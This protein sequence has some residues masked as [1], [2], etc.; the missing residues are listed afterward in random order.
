[1]GLGGFSAFFADCGLLFFFFFNFQV[2]MLI[3]KLNSS[4]YIQ[5]SEVSLINFP[6][7]IYKRLGFSFQG[8]II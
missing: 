1:M 7:S 2:L 8:D 6:Y 3:T 5:V 4:N